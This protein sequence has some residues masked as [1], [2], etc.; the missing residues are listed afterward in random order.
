MGAGSYN[1]QTRYYR[2]VNNGYYTKSR[3]EIFVEKELHKDM[4][5]NG[6]TLRESRDS[7]EHPES[8]AIIIALDVTGSMGHIPHDF[9][10][11]G[12]PLMIDKLIQ[13]GIEHPQVMFVAVGDHFVDNS[14]LQISQFES[15]DELLDQWLTKVHIESGGGGNGGESYGLVHLFASQSTS[16][17]CWEKRKQKGYL[18]TIGNEP[19]H[20]NYGSQY[21]KNIIGNGDIGDKQITELISDAQKTYNVYHIS[22]NRQYADWDELLGENSLVIDDYQE[23]PS[24]IAQTINNTVEKSVKEVENT[25][26]KDVEFL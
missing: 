8:L 24:L 26:L 23:I 12:L 13:S 11:D 21:I 14:P 2:A 17:D 25:V 4:D 9:V 6:V 10:K 16:I 18:F 20:K 22:V 7:E 15:N 19:V 5:P 1:S 3:D